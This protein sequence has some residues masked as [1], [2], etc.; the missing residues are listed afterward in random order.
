MTDKDKIHALLQRPLYLYT[1]PTELLDTLVLKADTQIDVADAP[2]AAEKDA[3]VPDATGCSTCNLAGF[4]DVS[5]Q[6][7]HMRSDLHRFNL[8]RK[9]AGQKIVY[10]DEFEQMLDGT[11]FISDGAFADSQI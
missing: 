5:Q 7:E 11:I 10:P 3:V 8:K 9:L 6:R 4:S 1:L 2:P